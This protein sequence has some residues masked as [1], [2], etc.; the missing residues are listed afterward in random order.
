MLISRHP[1]GKVDYFRS[2]I[3]FLIESWFYNQDH[4]QLYHQ[5]I[6][7]QVM[8]VVSLSNFLQ[9]FLARNVIKKVID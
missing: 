7:V 3:V 8:H 1:S 2:P 9:K 5:D 6:Y 4:F